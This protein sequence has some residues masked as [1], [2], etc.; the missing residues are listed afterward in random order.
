MTLVCTVQ[1]C[2]SVT[3]ILEH[4]L[5]LAE[6]IFYL[7]VAHKVSHTQ[8]G[9]LA[10]LRRSGAHY[11]VACHHQ[12]ASRMTPIEHRIF[13]CCFG[14]RQEVIVNR[15]DNITIWARPKDLSRYAVFI[16]SCA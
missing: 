9:A 1:F 4:V 5:T 16:A 14:F 6:R 3:F 10:F 2:L 8:I 12:F 7:V 11:R 15:P 13:T